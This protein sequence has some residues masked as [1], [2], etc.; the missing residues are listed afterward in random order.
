MQQ[1]KLDRLLIAGGCLATW[2][3]QAIECIHS[4]LR[5]GL[6]RTAAPRANALKCKRVLKQLRTNPGKRCNAPSTKHRLQLLF[7][8]AKSW[9]ATNCLLQQIHIMSRVVAQTCD[10]SE[11]ILAV[12]CS[13][14]DARHSSAAAAA[15]A[16]VARRCCS[17]EACNARG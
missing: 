2:R 12:W 17:I 14:P 7:H 13:H 15:A 6:Q 4:A 8:A 5:E 16:A 1:Q 9:Q 3:S 10:C 11:G